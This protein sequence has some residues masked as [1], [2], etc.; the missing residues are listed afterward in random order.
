M[1]KRDAKIEDIGDVGAIE[2]E[3]LGNWVKYETLFVTKEITNVYGGAL[4]S[5]DSYTFVS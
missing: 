3:V 2:G 1:V 4:G 5:T